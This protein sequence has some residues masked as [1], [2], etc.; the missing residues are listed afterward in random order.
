M[1]IGKALRSARD[2]LLALLGL[3]RRQV[4]PAW[5]MLQDDRA[6]EVYV[7]V[8]ENPRLKHIVAVRNMKTK[9]Y[10]DRLVARGID[11]EV[12]QVNRIATGVFWTQPNMCLS[13]T[14]TMLHDQMYT[15]LMHRLRGP[16][17]KYNVAA[18]QM[19]SQRPQ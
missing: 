5:R 13:C 1:N 7:F 19:G 15:Q 6:L 14:F 11:V 12:H 4:T 16:N 8:L 9:V 3:Q 10:F 17:A 18:R 2:R